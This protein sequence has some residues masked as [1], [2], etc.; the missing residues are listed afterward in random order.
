MEFLTIQELAD[1]ASYRVRNL[2]ISM[3]DAIT[4][5]IM[6][7]PYAKDKRKEIGIELNER[8]QRIQKEKKAEAVVFVGGRKII[9]C[10]QCDDVLRELRSSVQKPR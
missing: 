4:S 9:K 1:L 10:S 8:K 2:G 6:E 5:V 7:N 3:S